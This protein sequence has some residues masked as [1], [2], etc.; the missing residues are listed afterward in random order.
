VSTPILTTKL[1]RPRARPDLVAR[2]QLLQRLT[3]AAR[4]PLTILSA[5]AGFGKTTLLAAWLAGVGERVAWL[6]LDEGDNDPARFW[7]YCLAALQTVEPEIGADLPATLASPQPPPAET[8]LTP[9]LNDLALLDEPLT[10]VLDDYHVIQT[11][12]IHEAI[13]FLVE[14]L[15]PTLHLVLAGRTNPPLPLSRLRARGQLAEIRAADLRFAHGEIAEFLQEVVGA[16][17]SPADIAALESR[18]EGWIAGLQLAA[19]SLR[20]RSDASAFIQAFTGSHAYI[21]DYLVEEVLQRLPASTEQFLVQTA[22]LERLSGPLCEAVTQQAGA[23]ALL[24]GLERGN[25]FLI[26]LDTERRWYRYHHLFADVLRHRLRQ[27]QPALVTELHLRA[28]RWC[29]EQGLRAE[30]IHHAFAAQSP[31]EAA[32]LIQAEAEAA[33]KR[34]EYMTVQ[35]WLNRLPEAVV[36]NHPRLCLFWAATAVIT[37][38]LEAAQRWLTLAEEAATHDPAP[39]E[40]R[41]EAAAIGAGIA[42]NRG[43]FAQTL[44]LAQQALAALPPTN[45]RLRGEVMLHRGLARSW[46]LDPVGATQA[47][48]EAGRLALAAGDL[49]TAL[50]AMF[51]QGAQQLMHGR[52]QPAATT[53][54]QALQIASEQGAGRIPITSAL[55]RGLAELHYEWN[56]LDAA[57]THL[58]EAIERGERGGLPRV[59]VL[60]DLALARLH[61]A[62]GDTAAAITTINRA[63]H[64]VETHELPPRYASPPA[65]Y[66]A[67]LWLAQGDLAAAIAWAHEADLELAGELN[68]MYEAEYLTLARILIVQGQGSEA[69]QLAARLRAGA[70]AVERVNSVIEILVVEALA[71]EAQ[72]DHGRALAMVEQA[73]VLGQAGGYI[74]TFLDEGPPL[75]A[76][77]AGLQGR[78]AESIKPY[79]ERLLSLSAG[80]ERQ[81]VPASKAPTAPA[82][83]LPAGV[84]PLIEPLTDREREVLRYVATGLSDRQVAETM[85]VAIGTVKRHLNNV[86]G[87]LGVHSRTQ[88]LARARSLGLI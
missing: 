62:R 78:V 69:Q 54:R 14:H 58:Q 27:L 15:P 51:N 2:P 23:Q 82:P 80:S 60:N 13:T 52:L 44:A 30:A 4:R 45:L 10:L 42:L 16:P 36:R 55:H 37:H 6:A 43:N 24:E 59:I 81:A 5:P 22:I 25:L 35:G 53:Y 18:T 83:A 67:R 48:A 31:Q 49:H 38:D 47:Y 33:L 20:G 86:Y 17:L 57:A 77:L 39:G 56:E 8:I 19:L 32:V 76:L 40:I 88:A 9:L 46:S 34:G 12:A 65:A 64:L 41:A 71:Y 21:I 26:P 29:N 73:V 1:Y 66:Q 28:M 84:E 3:E 74:R 72:R 85:I 50:L 68:Y 70:E 87:K 63:L 79:L 75:A 61:Q 11:S 7:S